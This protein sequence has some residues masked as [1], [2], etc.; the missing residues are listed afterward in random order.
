MIIISII[1]IFGII[2]LYF[3]I[4]DKDCMFQINYHVISLESRV[5]F[6]LNSRIGIPNG[7]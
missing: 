5:A 4:R 2:E 3:W 7:N 1:V 6:G